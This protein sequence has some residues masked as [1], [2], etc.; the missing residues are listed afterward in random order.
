[1]KANIFESITRKASKTFYSTTILFPKSVRNDVFI[2]YSF[3][4]KADDYID[5]NPPQ[6]NKYNEYKKLT[7]ERLSGRKVNHTIINTFGALVE[8]KQI[9]P[10]LIRDFFISL[11]IDLNKK[12]YNSF[13]DL[14]KFTYGVSEVVGLLMAQVMDL[15]KKSYSSARKL[16]LAM[17]L[18]NIVRDIDEDRILGRVYIPQNELKKFKLPS[19]ITADEVRTNPH[20]FKSLMQY[21]INRILNFLDDAKK[22]FKYIPGEYILPIRTAA[23]IY[24]HMAKK[25]EK[26]PGEIFQRKMRLSPIRM[27]YIIL[28]NV[29]QTYVR[30]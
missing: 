24:Y 2:L 4:R 15:P 29:L 1:M 22:G 16:G 28:K 13:E 8:R 12:T 20:K 14:Q 6:I 9:D 25:I 10:G 7:L 23:E 11:E 17:Q 26:N 19:V 5:S 3:L 27:S 18:I 30:H 21:Q